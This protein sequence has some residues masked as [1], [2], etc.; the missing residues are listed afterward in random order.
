MSMCRAFRRLLLAGLPSA[1][2]PLAATA[3]IWTSPATGRELP[4]QLLE[5]TGLHPGGSQPVVFCLVNRTAPPPAASRTR[6]SS[7]TCAPTVTWS[8]CWTTPI[9]RRPAGRTSTATWRQVALAAPAPSRLAGGSANSI[10]DM[11]Q[12]Y[13]G[14][15]PGKAV[16]T[17]L[18]ETGD[19]QPP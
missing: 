17:G 1:G 5:P 12:E 4:L 16:T 10:A 6:A 18:L 3:T 7:A 15:F 2:L 9:T 8:S 14:K 19:I 11:G 13:R